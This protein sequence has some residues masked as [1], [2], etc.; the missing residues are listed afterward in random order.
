[1]KRMPLV[2]FA[3]A[4]LGVFS[5]GIRSQQPLAP[6]MRIQEGYPERVIDAL[7]ER[8]QALSSAAKN[9]SQIGIQSVLSIS[10][11]WKPGDVITV[12][13]QGGTVE[14][15]QNIY[16]AVKPWTDAANLTLDFGPSPSIG[17]FREWSTTDQTYTADIRIGFNPD[18]YWSVVGND[19]IDNS[20]AKPNQESMNF[21]GFA[22]GLPQDWQGVVLHEFGHALGF[23]HEHQSPGSPCETEFRWDDDPGYVPTRDSYGQFVQD[24]QGRRPGIYT[25]LGG[26]PNGW[27]REKIDYNLKQLPNSADWRASVFDKSSIMKYYFPD[28]MFTNGSSSACYSPESLVLSAQDQKA[29]SETYPRPAHDVREVLNRQLAAYRQLLTLSGLPADLRNQYRANMRSLQNNK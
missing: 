7:N 6:K 23:E 4:F 1:M 21:E 9:R 22:D 5:Y 11:T 16:G 15:R 29:A 13:F 25:R 28:W 2:L 24:A 8:Q 12:A 17:N 19:S 14:L 18:G 26:P 3:I 27:K 20:V 10:R